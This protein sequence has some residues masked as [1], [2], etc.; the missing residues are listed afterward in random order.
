MS[1][2]KGW[3]PKSDQWLSDPVYFQGFRIRVR[4]EFRKFGGE[5]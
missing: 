4:S 1:K 5:G 2:I 3:T